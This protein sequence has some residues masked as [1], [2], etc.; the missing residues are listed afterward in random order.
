MPRA[1]RVHDRRSYPAAS[2]V[3]DVTEP[4]Q[5]PAGFAKLSC[6][7][8]ELVAQWLPG[9][10][11]VTDHSWGLVDTAVV[12]AT[13]AGNRF[14][15][16]AGGATN[17]HLNRE[18]EAHYHWLA[19]WT[20][21]GRAPELVA[22]DDDA[23]VLVTRYLPGRLVLD[24]SAAR[25]PD[26][27]R[28]AGHLLSLIHAQTSAVDVDYETRANR[29]S[30]AWLDGPHRIAPATVRR[31]RA[32]ID[33]WPIGPVTVVPTHGDW[34]PRNWIINEGTLSVIDFGRAAL[35]PAMTDLTRLASREF[36]ED[37]SL[38][39]AFLDG[40]GFDPRE[41]DSW[42]RERVRE[43]IGTAAWAYQVG[44]RPFEG[45]GHRMIE[46]ALDTP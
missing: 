40:Y 15:I 32:L 5:P 4:T 31:L 25:E 20:A 1:T 26:T 37:G 8:R 43:A 39:A 12:E 42:F 7:Q 33:S 29:K 18:I 21:I 22:A 6:R 23:K 3:N 46:S 34:Q 27:Y 41:P 10:V 13:Y 11:P 14:I 9:A 38:E 28:Q 45:H 2:I 44:D 16:K 35:R 36:A 17:H 19:P 30:M 24:T